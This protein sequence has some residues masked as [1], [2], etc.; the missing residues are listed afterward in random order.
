MGRD[1]VMGM[2]SLVFSLSAAEF[3]LLAG[4]STG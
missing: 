3:Q 4:K 2:D 1:R